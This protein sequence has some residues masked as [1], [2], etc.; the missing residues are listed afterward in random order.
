MSAHLP[1]RQIDVLKAAADLNYG[2]A[3]YYERSVVEH[4]SRVL[5]IGSKTVGT[6]LYR[7]YETLGVKD[8]FSAVYESLH[9]RVITLDDVSNGSLPNLARDIESLSR[10]EKD[11]LRALAEMTLR[12]KYKG[13]SMVRRNLNMTPRAFRGVK[14]RTYFKL[15]VHN[16]A[17]LAVAA[18]LL[19][20]RPA[21]RSNGAGYDQ[22]K[23]T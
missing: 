12:E 15:G 23:I 18:Y 20:H 16:N 6:H 21:Q 4:I 5:G 13:K 2:G 22:L 8:I 3:P 9:T 10:R 11:V 17:Q 7:M 14:W 19:T 1:P